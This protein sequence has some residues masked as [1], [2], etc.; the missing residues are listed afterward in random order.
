MPQT[1]FSKFI[2]G[3]L[4]CDK[5]YEDKQTLAFLDHNPLT[6]GHTL[7]IP[8]QAVD[9]LDDCDP[10]IYA[11]VF[12]TVHK[13]SEHLKKKL[14]PKR[15]ALIVHGMDVPHAH[16]HVVPLYTGKELHLADRD[17]PKPD[18]ANLAKLAGQLRLE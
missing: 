14:N 15:I 9:H 10:E 13:V 2:S 18:Y 5:I 3:E 6:K 16:V 1:V 17:D 4:P 11:A 8:K 7:V 12:R